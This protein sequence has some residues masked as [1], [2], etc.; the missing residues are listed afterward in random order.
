[1]FIRFDVCSLWLNVKN[2]I[3]GRRRAWGGSY[4]VSR[5]AIC[6]EC[7][8]IEE[9]IERAPLLRRR[10]VSLTGTSMPWNECG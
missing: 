1:M 4:T 8:S 3:L 9:S 7:L 6:Q 2:S 5:I 10:N